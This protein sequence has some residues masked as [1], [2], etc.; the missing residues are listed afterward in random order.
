MRWKFPLAASVTMRVIVGSTTA[1]PAPDTVQRLFV[2][3]PPP[4]SIKMDWEAE[5][6]TFRIRLLRM[7]VL[8]D[9]A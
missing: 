3:V 2:I 5:V 9:R 7:I 4:F 1:H 6:E 8:V